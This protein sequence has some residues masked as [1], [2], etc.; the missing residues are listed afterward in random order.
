LEGAPGPLQEIAW[1][2]DGVLEGVASRDHSFVVGVQWHPEMM[3]PT[4]ETQRRLFAAFVEATESYSN[5]PSAPIQK[6][7]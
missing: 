5:R 3:A 2:E 7:A 4:D 6:T 1:A